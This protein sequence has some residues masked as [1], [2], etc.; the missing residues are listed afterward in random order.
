[1]TDDATFDEHAARAGVAAETPPYGSTAAAAGGGG[2]GLGA[3][4]GC[5][6]VPRRGGGPVPLRPELRGKP[7]VVG[8]QGDPTQRAVVATASDEA[9]GF[10]IH[11]GVPLCTAARR[12]PD[13]VF[14]PSDPPVYEAVSEQVMAALRELTVVEVLGWDEAFLGARTDGPEAL[15][16]QARRGVKEASRL[17]C[18]VGIGDNAC[19]PSSPSRLGI[20]RLTRDSWMA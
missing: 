10:G 7:V 4:C 11:S 14:L 5:R 15:A 19:G 12:C 16:A 3:S 1:M 9:C 8:G 2:A 6:R 18:S 13:A 17:S 20:Y